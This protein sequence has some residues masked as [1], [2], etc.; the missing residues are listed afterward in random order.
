VPS[1][2]IKAR[3]NGELP[4]LT[5]GTRIIKRDVEDAGRKARLLV[6]KAQAVAARIVADAEAERD[7]I[8]AEAHDAG[9]RDG[10]VQWNDAVAQALRAKDEYLAACEEDLLRL[11]VKIAG[12]IIGEQLRLH[13]E[14]IASIVREALKSAPRERRLTIQVNPSEVDTVNRHLRKLLESVT[15]H[16]P[17][18][19]V[20]ASET[21]AAGGCVIVSELGRV[22]AQ[23]ET[24]LQAMERVL[25]QARR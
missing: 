9:Y 1:S 5:A 7:R 14:T 20:V 11:A 17:E 23:L 10:L 3:A 22:D 12:K 13:P 25:L 4:S 18:V 2:I 19:E 6:E 24:Q 15:F 21:V 8:L 16:P